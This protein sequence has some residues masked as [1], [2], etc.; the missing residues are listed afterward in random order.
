MKWAE[1]PQS[2]WLL[3][4]L[5]LGLQLLYFPV[6]RLAQGGI[7]LQTALDPLIPLVPLFTVPYLLALPWWLG[8]LV[9]AAARMPARLYRALVIAALLAILSGTL[10]Y[11]FYPT[12]VV[13]QPVSQQG[14]AADLL[15]WVYSNDRTYNAFPSSHTYLTALI[16][17]FWWRWQP[18]LRILWAGILLLVLLSTLL[19]GQHTLPDVAGGLALAA[20]CSWIGLRVTNMAEAP[21]TGS[22]P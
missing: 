21:H 6:N 19:T 2:R 22:A 1:S 10:V 18:R 14:W 4:A 7:M 16:C 17:L 5:L 15:R 20:V 13:R 11:I 8:S 9:W 12:Y 3:L